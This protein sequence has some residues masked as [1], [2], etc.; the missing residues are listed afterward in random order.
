MELLAKLFVERALDFLIANF[1]T[2]SHIHLNK[3]TYNLGNSHGLF[4]IQ[5]QN[6][7]SETFCDKRNLKLNM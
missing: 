1:L 7:S 6:V 4:S 2:Y 3:I 5:S